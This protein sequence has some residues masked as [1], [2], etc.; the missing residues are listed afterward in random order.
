MIYSDHTIKRKIWDN[1]IGFDP[2]HFDN[3]Q[4]ASIDITL[5]D[6]FLEPEYSGAIINLDKPIQ[7]TEYIADKTNGFVL[8]PHSFILASTAEYIKIPSDVTA[9]IEGR[10][11][12]GRVGLFIQNAGWIDPGF[13]GTITLELFNASDFCIR[14]IPGTKVGQIIFAELDAPCQKPYSGKYQGQ[15]ETTGSKIYEDFRTRVKES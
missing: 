4:P 12:I 1:E 9:W 14:L 5:S 2:F 11:S 7:Y 13:E 15:K 8:R 3:V 6:K 10:S